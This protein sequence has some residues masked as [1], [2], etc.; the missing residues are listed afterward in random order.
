MLSE[1]MYDFLPND[2][3]GEEH[4]YYTVCYLTLPN[5]SASSTFASS[6]SADSQDQQVE[7]SIVHT[8]FRQVIDPRT[9]VISEQQRFRFTTALKKLNLKPH[10]HLSEMEPLIV[11]PIQD[12]DLACLCSC[13]DA[14]CPGACPDIHS[15]DRPSCLEQTLKCKSKGMY[16]HSLRATHMA[17]KLFRAS[18]GVLAKAH[19]ACRLGHNHA[20]R[21]GRVNSSLDA[22]ANEYC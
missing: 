18:E 4:A 21:L 14:E 3:T 2:Q 10:Y 8:A 12:E 17:D 7:S 6:V 5:E 16:Q 13:R 19:A 11:H 9:L 15:W 20:F 1:E 22:Q